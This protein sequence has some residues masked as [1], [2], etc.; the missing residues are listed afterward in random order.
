MAAVCH[1]PHIPYAQIPNSIIIIIMNAVLRI[2]S[3]NKL[4][5]IVGREP[6]FAEIVLE[7]KLRTKL[8]FLGDQWTEQCEYMERAA[9]IKYQTEN[10]C[11]SLSRNWKC[12][13]CRHPQRENQTKCTWICGMQWK[14]VHALE[15]ASEEAA[16][17]WMK[18]T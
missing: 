1:S 2:T 8:K 7:R 16:T 9:M 17:D 4:P 5:Y 18:E 15:M 13:G 10:V 11:V 6:S 12:S 3:R 14:E